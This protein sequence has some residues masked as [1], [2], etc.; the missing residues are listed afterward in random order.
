M[1]YLNNQNCK[2]SNNDIIVSR[3]FIYI[4]IY[5]YIFMINCVLKSINEYFNKK[6][7]KEEILSI[8]KPRDEVEE[9]LKEEKDVNTW[10]T[11]HNGQSRY[12]GEWKDGLPHGKGTKE[13]FEGEYKDDYGNTFDSDG[14]PRS[15]SMIEG[16][17]VDGR[18]NGYGKQ[19]YKQEG[20]KTQPYY[21]GEFYNGFHNGQGVY[22][23]GNGSYY[24][25]NFKEGKFHGVGYHYYVKLNKTWVGIF[26][27]DRKA[28][29]GLSIDGKLE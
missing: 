23:Y 10:Y 16:S 17:F 9:E 3:K 14:K 26:D 18:A 19:F 4:M 25:G 28:S 12:K 2:V 6:E 11:I 7:E 20:E 8:V 1:E 15:W 5:L 27:F 29:K 21:E 22:Y 24:K 13:I